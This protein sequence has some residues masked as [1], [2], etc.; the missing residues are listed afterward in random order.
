MVNVKPSARALKEPAYQRAPTDMAS[1][2]QRA[3]SGVWRD[4]WTRASERKS[5]PSRAWANVTRAPVRT[6]EW[7]EPRAEI[8]MIAVTAMEPAGPIR[9]PRTVGATVS[10]ERI[11]ESGTRAIYTAFTAMYRKVTAM[12]PVR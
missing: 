3:T 6:E 7:E 11:S 5:R 8:M 4:G 1:W 2:T 12:V 10:S 9:R